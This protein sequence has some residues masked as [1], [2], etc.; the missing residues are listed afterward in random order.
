V[1]AN[2]MASALTFKKCTAEKIIFIGLNVL[3]LILTVFALSLGARELNPFMHA[4]INSPYLL[5]V[6]K[7]I[8]P[9]LFA[10]LAPGKLLIPAILLLGLVA[11]W[12]V[13]ELLFLIF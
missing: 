8:I 9:C 13:R 6:V 3:D 1:V 5:L 11:G 7:L 12:N 10:W 4:I 2:L